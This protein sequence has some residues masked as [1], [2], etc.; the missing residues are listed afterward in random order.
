MDAIRTW[1]A[2]Y[3]VG[4][5]LAVVVLLAILSSRIVNGLTEYRLV[6]PLAFVAYLPAVDLLD[7][8][9]P[10][11]LPRATA[12]AGPFVAALLVLVARSVWRLAIRQ[13]RSTGS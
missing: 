7:K 3:R 11:G 8:P 6:V 1:A 9:V 13:Y 5:V 12:W 2:R 10:F 4:I